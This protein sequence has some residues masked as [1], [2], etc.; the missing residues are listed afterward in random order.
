[1]VS[2]RGRWGT[3]C[4]RGVDRASSHG[5]STSPLDVME[6]PALAIDTLPISAF[7]GDYC[8]ASGEVL[9]F[10]VRPR[11]KSLG[12]PVGDRI[13]PSLNLEVRWPMAE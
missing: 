3:V 7:V 13:P 2:R 9:T 10:M 1:V 8:R 6:A 12:K 11:S 4:A 5:S